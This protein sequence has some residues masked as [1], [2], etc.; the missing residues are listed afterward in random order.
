[1]SGP[2]L[3]TWEQLR[4][5]DFAAP[6]R[7]RL[8]LA[9]QTIE[10]RRRQDGSGVAE[11]MHLLHLHFHLPSSHLNGQ[12][13]R[14]RQQAAERREGVHYH[15]GTPQAG[16]RGAVPHGVADPL[17]ERGAHVAQQSEGE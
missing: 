3:R 17:A 14:D 5:G 8:A 12:T 10:L 15:T 2:T 1:M 13:D 9:Q 11:R 7:S 6:I 4:R 16:I